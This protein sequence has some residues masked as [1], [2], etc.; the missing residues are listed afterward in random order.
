MSRFKSAAAI[1]A[2]ATAQAAHAATAILYQ[3]DFSSITP[4]QGLLA[5]GTGWHNWFGLNDLTVRQDSYFGINARSA[6]MDVNNGRA[7]LD[8]ALPAF[9][10]G[11]TAVQL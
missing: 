4:G 10:P 1:L 7:G 6:Q 11:A 8:H 5:S 3:E 2:L 9:D